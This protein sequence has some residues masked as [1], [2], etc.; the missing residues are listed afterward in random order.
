[1]KSGRGADGPCEKRQSDNGTGAEQVYKE[2]WADTAL[3]LTGDTEPSMPLP[4]IHVVIR[5]GT[6]WLHAATA[7]RHRLNIVSREG[8]FSRRCPAAAATAAAAAVVIT[9]IVSRRIVLCR[10]VGA[11]AIAIIPLLLLLLLVVAK[12][13]A[14]GHRLL[15]LPL[16]VV[17][18]VGLL[19]LV[20]RLPLLLGGPGGAALQV[21]RRKLEG[22]TIAAAAVGPL[23][24]EHILQRCLLLL[25]ELGEWRARRVIW[26]LSCMAMWPSSSCSRS[27]GSSEQR[28]GLHG[29]SQPAA[30]A[31]I[32]L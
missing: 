17:E 15:L 25:I 14:A 13:A 7:A 4:I 28:L 9:A 6:A 19:L 5:L 8:Y 27:H 10:L 21:R 22:G 20:I 23:A 2:G 16:L 3:P 1:M 30:V 11:A 24:L 18:K 12:A 29:L 32:L 31:N 26:R